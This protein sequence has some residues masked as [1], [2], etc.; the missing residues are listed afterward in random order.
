VVGA[1]RCKDLD[2]IDDWLSGHGALDVAEEL[3]LTT[4]LGT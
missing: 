2:G 4:G 1:D 3:V